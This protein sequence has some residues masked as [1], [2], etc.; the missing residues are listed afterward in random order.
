LRVIFTRFGGRR[1]VDRPGFGAKSV[2]A[3]GLIDP[4]GTKVVVS[5]TPQN[6]GT[7][8]CPTTARSWF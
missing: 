1:L 3:Q 8:R 2:E 5:A 4:V 7:A 6:K